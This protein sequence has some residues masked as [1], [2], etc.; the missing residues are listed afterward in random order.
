M[1][2]KST[3]NTINMLFIANFTTVFGFRKAQYM[4]KIGL[5]IAIFIAFM[6]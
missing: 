4:L 6:L 5:F 1:T 2:A 3:K